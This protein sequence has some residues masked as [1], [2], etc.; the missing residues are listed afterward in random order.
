MRVNVELNSIDGTALDVITAGTSYPLT[1]D[2]VTY[3][4]SNDGVN[5]SDRHN[6]SI[7]RLEVDEV[8]ADGGIFVLSLIHI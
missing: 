7:Y 4:Q 3:G 2:F 6:N 1:M 5:A 8:D